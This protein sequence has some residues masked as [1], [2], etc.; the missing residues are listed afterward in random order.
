MKPKIFKPALLLSILL[1]A[2]KLFARQAPANHA[3][4][5]AENDKML[6]TENL[7]QLKINMKDMKFDMKESFKDFGE[8][9]SGSFAGMTPSFGFKDMDLHGIVYLKNNNRKEDLDKPSDNEKLKSYSKSYPVDAN[10]KLQIDNKYGK[11]TINTWNKNEF[12]VDVQIKVSA[13]NNKDAQRYIDGISV[14]D[15][16]AGGVVSFETNFGQMSTQSGWSLWNGRNSRKV[17]VNYIVYMP[18]KNA[19]KINNRYGATVLPDFDGKIAISSAYGSFDAQALTHADND[20]KVKY[21]SA[22]I[23]SLVSG[24]VDVAYGSLDIGS[25]DKLNADINYS[26]VKISKL[27]NTAD[28]NA[29]YAG[30]VKI[31][32]LDKNF[33]SLTINGLYSGIKVGMNNITADFDIAVHYGSFSFGDI[34][35]NVI[36]K[37]PPDSHRGFSPTQTYKGHVGKGN[38]EK[39]INI[40]SSF[41]SVQFE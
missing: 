23:E 32:E 39:T 31:S 37:T 8:S 19:L 4:P 11:V 3:S 36:E 29:R 13:G 5:A 7:K 38:S 40:R 2:G 26:S 30:T 27:K 21:G 9:F 12:K 16:K 28:I 24:E 14:T 35:V 18:A 15:R 17:E 22:S 34:P 25:A 6:L 10:D 41:G 1:I 20:I 33:S